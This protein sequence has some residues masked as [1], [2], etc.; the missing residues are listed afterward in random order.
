M[1]KCYVK[2]T[3]YYWKNSD[4]YFRV[5]LGRRGNYLEKSP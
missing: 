1:L 4:I 2:D 3:Y 5:F